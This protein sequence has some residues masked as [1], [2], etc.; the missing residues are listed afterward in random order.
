MLVF[1]SLAQQ[2][3]KTVL[4]HYLDIEIILLVLLGNDL[5]A[6]IVIPLFAADA[7]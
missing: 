3:G 6:S 1:V 7:F 5:N 2:A 4:S